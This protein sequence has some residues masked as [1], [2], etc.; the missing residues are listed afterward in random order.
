MRRGSYFWKGK[1]KAVLY[2][3]TEMG[4]KLADL[5]KK[6]KKTICSKTFPH[7]TKI[8]SSLPHWGS[9]LTSTGRVRRPFAESCQHNNFLGEIVM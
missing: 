3:K 7:R 9:A 2:F 8:P 6:K 5:A 4:Y 1:S